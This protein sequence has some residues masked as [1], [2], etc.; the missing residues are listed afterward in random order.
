MMI[1][2]C[3]FKSLKNGVE[4]PTKFLK[5]LNWAYKREHKIDKPTD[6]KEK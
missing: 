1:K 6:P 3:L 5:E 4:N 2:I